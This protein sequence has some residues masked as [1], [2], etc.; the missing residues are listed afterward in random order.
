MALSYK[1]RKRWSLFI[2]LVGL[3]VYIAAVWFLLSL[4]EGW[5]IW[6]QIV[7]CLAFSLV[8]AFPLRSVFLGVGKADPDEALDE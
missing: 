6:V 1:A 5:N 3:P 8:W 4:I 2:L 7:I